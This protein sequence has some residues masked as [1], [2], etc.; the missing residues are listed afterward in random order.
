MPVVEDGEVKTQI[1]GCRIS[2]CLFNLL[3]KFTKQQLKPHNVR[4]IRAAKPICRRTT[5]RG[6]VLNPEYNIFRDQ[7]IPGASPLRINALL[8]RVC[9]IDEQCVGSF[10]NKFMLNLD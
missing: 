6:K 7:P 5:E 10:K 1:I 2:S 4:V 9:E 8:C 3:P